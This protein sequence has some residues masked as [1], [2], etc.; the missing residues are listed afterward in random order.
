MQSV[1]GDRGDDV[2]VV[3]EGIDAAA[4]VARI[5]RTVRDVIREAHL[6][7]AWVVAIAPSDLRGRW[8]VGLKGQAARHVFTFVATEAQVPDV[9][10]DHLRRA[11]ERMRPLA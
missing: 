3:V 7:G 8:D 10:G 11:I 5:E 6:A 1:G 4:S 2:T 9:I